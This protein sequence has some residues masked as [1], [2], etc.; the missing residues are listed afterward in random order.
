MGLRTALEAVSHAGISVT[1]SSGGG[2]RRGRNRR[3][4]KDKEP[5]A[6][7]ERLRCC[8]LESRTV[9]VMV[10]AVHCSTSKGDKAQARAYQSVAREFYQT[11]HGTHEGYVERY[12]VPGV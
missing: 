3:A 7:V 4:P 6:V 10:Y 5:V 8:I 9:D 11:I 2:R 12:G 1:L